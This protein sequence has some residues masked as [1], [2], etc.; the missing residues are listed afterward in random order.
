MQKKCEGVNEGDFLISY[1]DD[2]HV[3]SMNNNIQVGYTKRKNI[4]IRLDALNNSLRAVEVSA[5]RV[6]MRPAAQSSPQ[7]IDFFTSVVDVDLP[8]IFRMAK[9]MRFFD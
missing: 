8:D 2:V 9:R 6:M 4:Q 7:K 1:E 3:E 5:L